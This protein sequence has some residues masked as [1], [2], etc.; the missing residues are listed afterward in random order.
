MAPQAGVTHDITITFGGAVYGMMIRP[1]SLKEDRADEFAPRIAT[2]TDPSLREG[3]WDAWSQ[4]GAQEGIDQ[5]T[6]SNRNKVY[7]SDGNV[8]L[9]KDQG[10]Q[11][12][13]AWASS[14]ASKSATAPQFVDFPGGTDY[15]AAGI[16]TKIR[17]YNVSTGAWSDSTTTL[18]ASAVWLH[19]HGASLFVGCGSGNDFYSSTD[20]VTFTAVSTGEKAAAF[21]SLLNRTSFEMMLVKGYQQTIKSSTDLGVNW[22]TIPAL[23]TVGTTDSNITGLGVAAGLLVIGKEDGLYYFDGVNVVEHWMVPQLKHANNFKCMVFHEGF[24]YTNVMGE[25]V[26]IS[27]SGGGISN[28]AFITPNM[29]GDENKEL[30]GHGFPVWMWAGPERLYVAFDDGESLYPE[31]LSYNGL[32]WQQEYRGASGDNMLAGGY[33]KLAARTFIND[34]AS[35]IRRGASLVARDRDR[36]YPDYPAT[37]QFITSDFDGGLPFMYKAFREI[38]VEAE[39]VSGGSIQLAYSLDKGSNYVDLTNITVSGKTYLLFPSA[40]AVA[41]ENFRLRFTV[42]RNSATS[43]PRIRRWATWFL[44][45]PTP[46]Y[47]HS[48]RLYLADGQ[49]IRDGNRETV[50]MGE[51]LSFLRGA[52]ASKTQG[53]FTDMNDRSWVVYVTRSSKSKLPEDIQGDSTLEAPPDEWDVDLVMIEVRSGGLWDKTYWDAWNWS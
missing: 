7:W 19:R 41:S 33:S 27:F 18:G 4:T 3:I 9:V 45:R 2:G 6:Y 43:T 25:V 44:T 16:G 10:I 37:G 28:L 48:V 35:R 21:C 47:V 50:S 53:T 23:T 46:I 49:E 13:S 51:R 17:K 32:G 40:E 30:Y 38:A 26:K 5:L 52:E 12:N 11:L 42:A 29:L 39:N 36:P 22:G 20:L 15:V 1:G 34:G 8:F 24:L 31:V 14:D